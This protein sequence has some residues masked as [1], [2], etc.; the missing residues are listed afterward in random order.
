M[1]YSSMAFFFFPFFNCAAIGT[2][3]IY[4]GIISGDVG[5]QSELLSGGLLGTEGARLFMGSMTVFFSIRK[6][7]LYC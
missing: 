4:Q 6:E 2:F 3:A 5:K 7:Y 1:F